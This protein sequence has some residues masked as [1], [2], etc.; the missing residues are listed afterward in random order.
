[1][2]CWTKQN[3]ASCSKRVECCLDHKFYLWGCKACW[4]TIADA[5]CSAC[6]SRYP[7]FTCYSCGTLSTSSW[8]DLILLKN[9]SICAF[10]LQGN[11]R[12]FSLAWKC[13]VTL[14]QI[15]VMES[16]QNTFIQNSILNTFL[17]IQKWILFKRKYSLFEYFLFQKYSEYFYKPYWIKIF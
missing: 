2:L 10:I 12:S 11:Y 8:Y 16:I 14:R 9:S 7:Y 13:L 1:M 6:C 3:A 15:A 17:S 4:I 5:T